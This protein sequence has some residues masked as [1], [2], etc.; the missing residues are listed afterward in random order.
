MEGSNYTGHTAQ[1]RAV[2]TIACPKCGREI[3]CTW[4]NRYRDIFYCKDCPVLVAT[5]KDK[6]E[7]GLYDA[8]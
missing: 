6:G 7:Q 2:K 3:P 8:R 1:E 5:K 4:S